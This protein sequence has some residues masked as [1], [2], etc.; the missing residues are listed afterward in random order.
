[1]DVCGLPKTR[2]IVC[3]DSPAFQRHHTSV[4]CAAESST[5]FPW[6]IDTTSGVMIYIRWCCI[7]LLNPPLLSGM[8]ITSQ[9]PV[10][11]EQ[12]GSL[13][14]GTC[15]TI[16]PEVPHLDQQ[17]IP[18][19]AIPNCTNHFS[20]VNTLR[21]SRFDSAC[22]I[23]GFQLFGGEFQIQTGEIVLELRYLPRSYDRD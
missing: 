12:A 5:R 7:D 11:R 14:A 23:E 19:A 1:M 4:R 15:I 20:V 21:E 18:R 22:S 10:T 2:P 6:V 3:N 16:M 13:N 17:A 8:C 9:L